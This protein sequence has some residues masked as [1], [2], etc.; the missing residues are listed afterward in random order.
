MIIKKR[1]KRHRYIKFL[2]NINVKI[3]TSFNLLNPIIYLEQ[4]GTDTMLTMKSSSPTVPT[5]D[6]I[7]ILNEIE[8][9]LL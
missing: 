1:R 6:A 3:M 7:Q 8:K 9:G 5:S 4:N 2:V